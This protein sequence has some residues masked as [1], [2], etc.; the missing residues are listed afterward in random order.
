MPDESPGCSG[1]T[2]KHNGTGMLVRTDDAHS[3]ESDTSAGTNV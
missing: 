2:F 1:T 3:D